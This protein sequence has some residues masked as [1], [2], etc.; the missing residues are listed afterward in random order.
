M[1]FRGIL[2][3]K[4]AHL[5]VEDSNSKEGANAAIVNISTVQ[6]HHAT[7]PECAGAMVNACVR[8]TLFCHK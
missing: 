8:L 7:R 2:A 6:F 1:V 3:V 5:A 4:S